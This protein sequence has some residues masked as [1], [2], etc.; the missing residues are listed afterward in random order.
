M[1]KDFFLKLGF[2]GLIL[3]VSLCCRQSEK[4]QASTYQ[5]GKTGAYLSVERVKIPIQQEIQ[6]LSLQLAEIKKK[7]LLFEAK[8]LESRIEVLHEDMDALP[9]SYTSRTFLNSAG[10]ISY[11]IQS[12]PGHIVK[13]VSEKDQYEI[14]SLTR[15]IKDADNLK[16]ELIQEG[17]IFETK[18]KSGSSFNGTALI[19]HLTVA[20]NQLAEVVIQDV[21]SIIPPDSSIMKDEIKKAVEKLP[22]DE[23]DKYFLVRTAMLTIINYRVFNESKF[24]AGIS[25]SYITAN[26][27]TYSSLDKMKKERKISVDLVSLK[28]IL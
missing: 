25:C 28:N 9:V 1:K 11:S 7:D 19:A 14:M 13:Y 27:K 24:D 17:N 8:Q 6:T 22:P 15:F 21:A 3:L 20:Q 18:V 26:R 2:L 4:T 16:P 10:P 5:L 12:I 23:I